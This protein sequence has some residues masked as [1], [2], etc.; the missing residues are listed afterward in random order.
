MKNF[1]FHSKHVLCFPHVYS[2][3]TFLCVSLNKAW[4][5]VKIKFYSMFR[6]F[7]ANLCG[8]LKEH[9]HIYI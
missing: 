3:Y 7:Y 5:V 9:K 4:N 2:D 8:F 6:F 1:P